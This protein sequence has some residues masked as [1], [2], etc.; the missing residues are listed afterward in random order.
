[1]SLAKLVAIVDDEQ[2]ITTL[3]H[4]A[5][6]SISGITIFAFTDPIL[7]LEH[8]QKNK[9]AYVVVISDF[10]MPRLNG[11]DLLRKMKELKKYVR[12]VLMTAFEIEDTMFRDYTK[13]EIINGFFQKPVRLTNLIEEVNTQLHSYEMQKTHPFQRSH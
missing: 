12:T 7:A 3:F 2:D 8:F 13:K 6:R 5:L 4:D 9:D 11:M 10:T 1:L